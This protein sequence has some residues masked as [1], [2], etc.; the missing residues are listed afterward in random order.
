MYEGASA[1]ILYVV[2]Q[3]RPGSS[4]EAQMAMHSAIVKVQNI[5]A[6]LVRSAECGIS[7]T[8]VTGFQ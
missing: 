4:W 5:L 1:H 3:E 7:R 6:L 8:C 2:V